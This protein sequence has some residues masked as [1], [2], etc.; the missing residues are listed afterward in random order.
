MRD[1]IILDMSRHVETVIKIIKM[2]ITNTTA[3]ATLNKLLS[4]HPPNLIFPLCFIFC[5]SLFAVFMSFVDISL[6]VR[7]VLSVMENVGRHNGYLPEVVVS[8]PH[9]S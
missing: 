8:L 9:G 4:L 7:G 6:Y 2:I 3:T 1:K 5:F